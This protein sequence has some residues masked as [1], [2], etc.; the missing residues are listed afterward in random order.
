MAETDV[1][2]V[3]NQ[4]MSLMR[5]P[6]VVLD[7][8]KKAAKA[9]QGVLKGKP[10]KVIIRGEQYLEFEDYQTLGRFYGLSVKC[11]STNLI[12]IGGIA[13]YEAIAEVIHTQ[14]GNIVSRAESMCLGNEERWSGKPLFQVRSMAQTRAC[15]KAFRNCLAWV[16]VLAGYSGTPSEEM[17]REKEPVKPKS[18]SKPTPKEAVSETVKE[19]PPE[20]IEAEPVAFAIDM[21]AL[22][23]GLETLGWAD[24]GAYLK[25]TYKVTGKS[26]REM[27]ASLTEDQQVEF[28]DE[29]N[30]RL[31]MQ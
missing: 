30:S 31:E 23:D 11:V 26:V 18:T 22:R 16:V 4:D 9:L 7:E 25:R 14:T 13:G 5:N 12:E 21:E 2:I 28:N 6:D 1:A 19:A 17:E 15:A 20:P 8:A 29:V 24:A 27:V 10:K 3:E